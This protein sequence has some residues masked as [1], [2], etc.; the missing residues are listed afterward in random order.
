MGLSLS[1]ISNHKL[2]E[3][4]WSDSV[5]FKLI[6]FLILSFAIKLLTIEHCDFFYF[7]LSG[8]IPGAGG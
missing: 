5:F 8:V 7:P 4:T 1:H 3:L 6:F 2:V